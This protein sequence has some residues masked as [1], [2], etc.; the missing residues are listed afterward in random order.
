MISAEKKTLTG[1][2]MQNHDYLSDH[3]S[4][5]S[6][7]N[8]QK[9]KIELEHKKFTRNIKSM[10]PSK[11][12]NKDF[13]FKS[14]KGVKVHQNNDNKIIPENPSLYGG[15]NLTKH[16]EKK[17]K[18]IE[19]SITESEFECPTPNEFEKS[20]FSLTQKSFPNRFSFSGNKDNSVFSK[21]E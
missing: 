12:P 15:L 7:S 16:S 6:L 10:A 2:S 1:V 3:R 8:N 19:L 9:K 13:E 21:K 20:P 4:D 18:M 11:D 5:M 14:D 17:P